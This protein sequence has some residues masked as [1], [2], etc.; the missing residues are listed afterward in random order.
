MV[1]HSSGQLKHLARTRSQEPPGR[2]PPSAT[3]NK[4]PACGFNIKQAESRTIA[5]SAWLF[6]PA[7]TMQSPI[8]L[9]GH[10]KDGK[11]FPQKLPRWASMLIANAKRNEANA[12]KKR[13]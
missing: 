13:R 9:V 7:E 1:L 6:I 12:E 3:A 8:T 4:T 2:R 11:H 5:T 10:R